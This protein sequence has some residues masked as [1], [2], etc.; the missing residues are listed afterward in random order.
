MAHS[1]DQSTQWNRC[2]S[3]RNY[4]ML[5]ENPPPMELNSNI[6]HTHIH[7]CLVFWF[8][9]DRAYSR[10]YNFML[11]TYTIYGFYV[12]IY[13][14]VVLSD[15]VINILYH[16]T[17]KVY[18]MFVCYIRLYTALSTHTTCGMLWDSVCFVLFAC[19]VSINQNDLNCIICGWHF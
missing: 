11:N 19:T 3:H 6:L 9:I 1:I 5:F 18:A 15:T 8:N 13:W 16:G 2:I 12:T 10:P 7:I 4:H 14:T 17:I